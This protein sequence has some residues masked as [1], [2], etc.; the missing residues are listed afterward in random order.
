[1]TY[2]VFPG[3]GFIPAVS[4]ARKKSL[5][6][7]LTGSRVLTWF[8]TPKNISGSLARFLFL[9]RGTSWSVAVPE[10]FFDHDRGGVNRAHDTEPGRG[11]VMT[12][13]LILDPGLRAVMTA[14]FFDDVNAE[15]FHFPDPGRVQTGSPPSLGQSRVNPGWARHRDNLG[16]YTFFSRNKNVFGGGPWKLCS[17]IAVAYLMRGTPWF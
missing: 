15:I 1:M 3:M 4:W 11:S 12:P 7:T 13:D 5:T 6:P 10:I 17:G 14:Y 2:K 16:V 8:V 9:E